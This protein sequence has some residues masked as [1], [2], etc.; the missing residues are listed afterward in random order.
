MPT[1]LITPSQL[2]VAVLD[3]PGDRGLLLAIAGRGVK[4]SHPTLSRCSPN[5]EMP[6]ATQLEKM[7]KRDLLP[8]NALLKVAWNQNCLDIRSSV[9]AIAVACTA[10]PECSCREWREP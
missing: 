7:M 5:Q 8:V 10:Q 9:G 1:R 6:I 2:S 3:Q 4:F